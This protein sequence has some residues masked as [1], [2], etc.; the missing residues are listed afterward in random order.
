MDA[1]AVVAIVFAVMFIIGILV[2]IITVIALS[3]VR[4]DRRDALTEL[5][6]QDEFADIDDPESNYGAS[7]VPGHWDGVIPDDAPHWPGTLDD[8]SKGE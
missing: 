5:A 2:G 7:G 6:R 3:A 8:A 1:L 4:R